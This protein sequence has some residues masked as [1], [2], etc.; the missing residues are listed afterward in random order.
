MVVIPVVAVLVVPVAVAALAAGG[1]SVGSIMQPPTVSTFDQ[2]LR[3]EMDNAA[4]QS[5]I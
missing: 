5:V 2:E 1:G 3:K 4:A